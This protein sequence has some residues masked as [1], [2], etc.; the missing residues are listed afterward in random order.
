MFSKKIHLSSLSDFSVGIVILTNW[1]V[2]YGAGTVVVIPADR[3]HC[4]DTV[5]A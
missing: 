1:H 5:R 3:R 4:Q 2:V